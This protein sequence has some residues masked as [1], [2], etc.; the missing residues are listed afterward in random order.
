MHVIRRLNRRFGTATARL[1]IEHLESRQP[2]TVDFADSIGSAPVFFGNASLA[3]EIGDGPWGGRDVDLYGFQATAGGR[4]SADVDARS[5]AGGSTLDSYLRV[6]DSLGREMAFNDDSGGSLDSFVS[7]FLPS[8]GTYYVGVSGFGNTGYDPRWAE[9]GQFGSTGRYV[10]TVTLLDSVVPLPT[11]TFRSTTGWGLVD[12]AAAVSSLMGNSTAF[13]G[14][15]SLGGNEWANDLVNAPEV[16]ARGMTGRG[17]VVAVVDTGVDYNHPDLRQNIWVNPREVAGDGI[18]NDRNGFVD[19]VRGWDFVDNDAFPLDVVDTRIINGESGNPGHGTHVAGTI[20]AVRNGIGS[21]GVAP[22][23]RIMPVRVLDHRGTGAVTAIARGIRYAANN[24]ADVINLSLGGGYSSDIESAIRYA[25]SRGSVVVVAAGNG[26]QSQ[27][28]HPA[29]LAATV[30][31]VIAVGSVDRNQQLASRSDR[32]GIDSRMR[33]VVAP[34]V[35]V[36]STL[37]SGRYGIL[38]GTSM[39]APHVAGIAALMRGAVPSASP[40]GVQA[41]ITGT[42]RQPTGTA[43]DRVA[44]MQ[45]PLPGMM[46]M[47]A[48]AAMAGID[49]GFPAESVRP[50]RGF[51]AARGNSRP[52]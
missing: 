28:S 52:A 14:V 40:Q 3:G 32:A 51:L 10:L 5:L 9:S 43:M 24:G 1:V 6:F 39:A 30:A 15:P 17:V 41:R 46:R 47:M 21:T 19:D 42:A 26:G 16:W 36:H 35:S 4:L 2:M 25:V 13:A 11:P 7:V 23:S 49:A 37:P 50:G 22:D 29:R 18:D 8:S 12:A 31:G 38:S 27:P 48:F 45:P 34:G 44:S 33:Y 20:A